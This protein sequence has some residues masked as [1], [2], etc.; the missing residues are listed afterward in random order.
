[1]WTAEHSTVTTAD[2]KALWSIWTTAEGWPGHN[3]KLEWAR[4]DGPL[5]VGSRI[6]TKATNG[7]RSSIT[8]TALVPYE[9]FTMETRIPFGK[10]TFDHIATPDAKG[11]SLV[12]TYRLTITGPLTRVARRI[13]A[14]EMARTMPPVMDIIIHDAENAH[15]SALL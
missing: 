4:L 8:I 3:R 11:T 12:F 5:A 1:M 9:R 15:V 14:D 10:V 6:V 2:P 7:M 13:F